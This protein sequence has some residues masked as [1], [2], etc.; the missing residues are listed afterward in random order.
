M[1]FPFF[2][3]CG[4]GTAVLGGG[5]LT[6]LRCARLMLASHKLLTAVVTLSFPRLWISWNFFGIETFIMLRSFIL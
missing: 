1:A 4:D 3:L 6:C 5:A 2:S